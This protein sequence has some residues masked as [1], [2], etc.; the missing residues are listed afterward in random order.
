MPAV[1]LHFHIMIL[2]FLRAAPKDDAVRYVTFRHAT[3]DA[4][5]PARP[6]VHALRHDFAAAM[7]AFAIFIDMMPC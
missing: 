2:L 1:R 6:S 3:P 7:P 5:R 4:A